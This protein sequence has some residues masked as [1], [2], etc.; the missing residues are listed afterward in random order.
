MKALNG[1]KLIIVLDKLK[2]LN[3]ELNYINCRIRNLT[4]DF[5][6][7]IYSLE[8]Y[9][10]GGDFMKKEIKNISDLIPTAK[11]FDGER[12]SKD[13]IEGK[14]LIIKDFAEIPSRYEGRES[15]LVIQAQ[16]DD[17]TV[18]FT[19]STVIDKKLKL[20]GKENLPV[21]ATLK[22]VKGMKGR[23]YWDLV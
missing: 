14:E 2:D 4:Q 19:G 13:D 21:K 7:F 9:V 22:F 10:L 1:E 23:R 15:F 12:V 6:E 20:I 8:N 3:V 18:V 11:L 17:K 5:N 16:C